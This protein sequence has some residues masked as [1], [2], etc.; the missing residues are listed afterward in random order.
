MEVKHEDVSYG[1]QVHGKGTREQMGNIYIYIYKRQIFIRE[2]Y[3]SV[4][5]Y[6]RSSKNV[7]QTERSDT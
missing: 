1:P 3:I 5:R 6:N 4:G 7:L 2:T